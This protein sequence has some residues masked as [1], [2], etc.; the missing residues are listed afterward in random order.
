MI[1]P[2]LYFTPVENARTFLRH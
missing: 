2:A 1:F